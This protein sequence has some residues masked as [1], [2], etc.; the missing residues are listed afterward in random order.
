MAG[1]GAMR[2]VAQ[3]LATRRAVTVASLLAALGVALLGVAVG[4]CRTT[5]PTP[6]GAA[7]AGPQPE[8]R[9]RLTR[10]AEVVSL[11]AEG[12]ITL[13]ALGVAGAT[14][15]RVRPPIAL[16]VEG[17]GIVAV[18]TA[19]GSRAEERVVPVHGAEVV[20]I[21]GPG[22]AVR[23]DGAPHAGALEAFARTSAER[24]GV[25]IVEAVA[26]ESYIAG[27]LTGELYAAWAPA[28]YEAQAIAAR[29]YALHE[30][31]RRM[32]LGDHFHVE[33]TTQDQAYA[34]DRATAQA[35]RAA[36][37][38]RGMVL[39]FRDHI[40]R[41]YYSS[42]CGGRAGSARDTWPVGPGFG[43]NLDA[44]IQAH[45]RDC[46][47][48][49]SPRYIWAVERSRA[50]LVKRFSAWGRDNGHPIRRIDSLASVAPA[51]RNAAGRPASYLATD[52][53]GVAFS[54]SAEELRLA[55]NTGAKGLPEIDATT[56]VLS[57]DLVMVFE[58]DG[59]TIEGRGFGHGVGM[60]QFGAEGQARQGRSATEILLHYYRGAAIERAY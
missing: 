3:R 47:C 33:S 52:A 37:A 60:C 41:A 29:S 49:F 38:T 59:V 7:G 15:V 9:V 51:R 28:T 23:I 4:A 48:E 18:E 25:D 1:A 57:G 32:R 27:V 5:T 54:L 36:E 21:D 53:K 24:A 17:G 50:E 10:G 34:G 16:R 12:P 2:L 8:M 26:M 58:G 35:T 40:L 13:T 46:P 45:E 56:R 31:G 11:D 20:A 19:T 22:G 42:T 30:R 55:C 43:F 14:P 44:P 6:A 39:T